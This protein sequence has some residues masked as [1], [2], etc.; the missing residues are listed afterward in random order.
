MTGEELSKFQL[1]ITGD[2]Y[3][4][5]CECNN[6]SWILVHGWSENHYCM[7][8]AASTQL[9]LLAKDKPKHSCWVWLEAIVYHR[10]TECSSML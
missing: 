4:A 5:G 8:L 1:P 2:M 9:D 7:E 6:Y 10:N 3:I